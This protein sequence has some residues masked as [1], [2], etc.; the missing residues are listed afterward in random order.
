MIRVSASTIIENVCEN[1]FMHDIQDDLST[2]AGGSSDDETIAISGDDEASCSSSVSDLGEPKRLLVEELAHLPLASL[3]ELWAL[4]SPLL[5]FD[6]TPLSSKASV[7]KALKGS[8][9][10][11]RK[12]GGHRMAQDLERQNIGP[13][14]GL[15]AFCR[16]LDL[17]L[18]SRHGQK[19]AVIA[20]RTSPKTD[21][22]QHRN[23]PIVAV[24]PAVKLAVLP[25]PPMVTQQFHQATYR[26]ELSD[27]LRDL[28]N[29]SNVGASVRRIRIQNVP[30]ERQAAEF[31]DIL[32]RAAE[33]HR[34]VA[35][36]LSF[37]F[38]VGLAAGE[39]TSAFDR[40]ECAAG[41]KLFFDDVFE[42]LAAEVPRLR[43]KFANEFVPTL[44][45]AFSADEIC[46]LVPLDCRAV[47]G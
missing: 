38:A 23:P 1:Q 21:R 8:A 44:R 33:E 46:R 16:P 22:H 13:P 36:R 43:S 27:V 25:P 9:G 30:K 26:K 34:G 31:R 2:S 19:Q 17:S 41:I 20:C 12:V 11:C 6:S 42:D 28:A 18:A 4:L 29:G 5:V 15:E 45:T 10:R 37:A 7:A 40:D 47:L 39:P 35:R 3:W 32:T 24:P 14:P